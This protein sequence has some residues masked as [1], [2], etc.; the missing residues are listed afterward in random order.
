MRLLPRMTRVAS[1]LA[2]ALLL[3][4]LLAVAARA[5]HAQDLEPPR[6]RQ[7]Y[8][9]SYGLRGAATQ[10]YEKG[11]TLGPWFGYGA[12][13][14]AGQLVTRRF[15]LGL[16]SGAT[17]GDGQRATATALALE[18]GFAV[19]G[20]F[21]VRGGAGVGFLQL[22]NPNDPTESTTRGAAGAWFALG[23]SYDR[24]IGKK[25]LTGGWALTPVVQ[26]RYLPGGDT[27][28][29]IA[30]VGVDL[31]YWTGL[32]LNQLSLPPSEAWRASKPGN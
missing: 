27:S 20:N 22:K 31:T 12:A 4:A 17:R 1:L 23:V 19:A 6:Q 28:G 13:L 10:A 29:A 8:Y 21:A 26:A 32:P 9:L 24:F 18:A 30:F 25:R 15:S 16:A 5:A 14:R 7:G 11:D 3:S 2:F